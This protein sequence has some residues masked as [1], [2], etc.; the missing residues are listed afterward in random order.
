MPS[1]LRLLL[2]DG[3][4]DQVNR[5]FRRRIRYRVGAVMMPRRD[6]AGNIIPSKMLFGSVG[7]SFDPDYLEGVEVHPSH[8]EPNP[9]EVTRDELLRLHIIVAGGH[10][11]TVQE[12]IESLGYTQGLIHPGHPKTQPDADLLGWRQVMQVGGVG[13]GLR[14]IRSVGR[15]VHRALWPLRDD[16]LAKFAP[17]V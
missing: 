16:V 9:R 4:I 10:Y 3:L 1:L 2:M 5:E 14:E 13:A 12:V 7:D 6:E 17:A 11:F 15:V 8:K